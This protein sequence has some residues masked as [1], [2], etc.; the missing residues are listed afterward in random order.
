MT[1]REAL[2][3]SVNVPAVKAMYLA[4][5]K[6]T[7]ETA[8]SLGISSLGDY[9]RYGLTLVLGGGEV[10]LLE[11]TSAYGT[12]AHEGYRYA[13]N[14]ILEVQDSDGKVLEKSEPQG[15]QV[16]DQEIARTISDM[17]K[18][19][20]AR[21]PAF[22]ADSYLHFPGRDVAVKTG[23]TN[24]YRD[25]WI[26][27]YTPS[28]AVGCWAGNNNNTPME[29]KVAGFI[30]APMW[31]EFMQKYFEIKGDSPAVTQVP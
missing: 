16:I 30:V 5:M 13:E 22:G 6:E 17:L 1:F 19:N 8:R 14:A 24:D 3:Q 11:M 10:S 20:Q 31:N 4:G 12:F 9:R 21:T 23:T 25:T 7:I 2:A 15:T 26:L 28:I 29:K 18:D 27:G